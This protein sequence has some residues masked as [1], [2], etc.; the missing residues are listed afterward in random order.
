M[1]KGN[2]NEKYGSSRLSMHLPKTK[3]VITLSKIIELN[4]KAS[5]K[6]CWNCT[7]HWSIVKKARAIQCAQLSIHHLI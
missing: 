7:I 4:K 2:N 1:Q 6:V 5:D 3:P